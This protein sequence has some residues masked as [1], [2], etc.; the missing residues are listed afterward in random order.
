MTDTQRKGPLQYN[1][2]ELVWRI[3]IDDGY[4]IVMVAFLLHFIF[5]H[6]FC[7]P[8]I[9]DMSRKV[10]KEEPGKNLWNTALIG[11]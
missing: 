8:L 5:K 10:L 4:I 2:Q 1:L 3:I 7:S 6:E 9:N 11:Q